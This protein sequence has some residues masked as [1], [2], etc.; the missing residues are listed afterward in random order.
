[1]SVRSDTAS[2]VELL[3]AGADDYLIKPFTFDELLARV[4]A[5]LRRQPRIEREI[6]T[7]SDLRLDRR[8]QTV[9][10]GNRMIDLR[11]KEFMLLEYLMQNT[12]TVLSREMLLQHV[13][14]TNADLFSNTIE[15]HIVN[16]RC[17]LGKPQLIHTVHG[18]GYKIAAPVRSRA[19]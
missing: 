18:S 3:N 9:T 13:W 15:A 10:R 19:F 14:D 4:Q 11:R 5:L 8:A 12:G 2:K 7:V 1:L 17:K 6:L 16:L